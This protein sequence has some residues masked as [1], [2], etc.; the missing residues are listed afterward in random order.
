L[1]KRPRKVCPGSQRTRKLEGLESS[2]GHSSS[3]IGE[4]VSIGSA[5]FNSRAD[6][7]F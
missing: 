2:S 5:E 3:S 7:E 6:N 4:S 1:V